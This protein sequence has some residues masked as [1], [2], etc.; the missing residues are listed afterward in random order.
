MKP[1]ARTAALLLVTL[2]GCQVTRD[3]TDTVTAPV[4][5][6]GGHRE[7]TAQTVA[8]NSDITN[9]G[10]PLL[11]PTPT[12]RLA[13]NSSARSQS[14][15]KTTKANAS[16][17][18]R[19]AAPTVQFPVAKPVPGRSGLVFNPFNPHGAYIDVS[20]YAAGSKVKD[21]DSQKIFVVP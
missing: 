13:R 9:P 15:T 12:P 17:L 7:S 6:F 16:P 10:H 21:P 5:H 11:S 4:R 1:V 3:I 2:A 19:G 8:A 14:A 18:P 20:G